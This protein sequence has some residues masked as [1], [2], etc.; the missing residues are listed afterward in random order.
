MAK[1]TQRSS[2]S[3]TYKIN[4]SS[5]GTSGA[6]SLRARTPTQV[7]RTIVTRSTARSVKRRR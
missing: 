1:R 7:T 4:R 3:M 5:F 6:R 2:T